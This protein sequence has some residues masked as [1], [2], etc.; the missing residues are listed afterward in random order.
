MRYKVDDNSGVDLGIFQGTSK[1]ENTL[2][3]RGS[4]GWFPEK[5]LISRDERLQ[6]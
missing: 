1:P 2:L 4:G 5:S 6:R 3:C